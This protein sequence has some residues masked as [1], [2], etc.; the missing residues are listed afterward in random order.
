MVAIAFMVLKMAETII[1]KAGNLAI[2][3]QASVYYVMPRN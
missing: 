2:Y 1:L 3:M